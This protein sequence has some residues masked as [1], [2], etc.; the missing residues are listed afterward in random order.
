MSKVKAI[1]QLAQNHAHNQT[2]QKKQV[3]TKH[4]SEVGVSQWH[5]RRNGSNKVQPGVGEQI[6]HSKHAQV[7]RQAVNI[8]RMGDLQPR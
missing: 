6:R 7:E 5:R 8:R 3:V 2:V 1:H 4:E